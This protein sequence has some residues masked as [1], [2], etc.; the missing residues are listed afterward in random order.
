[1]IPNVSERGLSTPAS[2]IRKLA[3]FAEEAKAKGIKVYHLNIGQP[4]IQTPTEFFSTIKNY[5][6]KVLSYGPSNGLN[7]FR[8]ALLSYYKRNGFSTLE[9]RD[10]MVTT[11]GSEAVLF[12]MMAVAS[13]EEEIIVFE[14]M[15]STPSYKRRYGVWNSKFIAE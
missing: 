14:K 7:E 1:M 3:P 15:G 2:P 13:P 12:S 9:D 10:I 6:E 8:E 11:A 5:S 4:D